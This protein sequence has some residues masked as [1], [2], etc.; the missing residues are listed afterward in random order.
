MAFDIAKALG[1][2]SAKPQPGRKTLQHIPL[3]MIDPNPRNLYSM[4]GITELADNIET[5]GLL[6]P[7]IVK[8]TDGGRYMV[9][10]GHRRRAALRM[11]AERADNY[12]QSMSEEVPCLVE[13]PD[14]P[15]PGIEDP[16]T[17]E[18]A[19]ALAEEL[20]LIYANADTRVLSSADT[21]MQ[22]R[23]IRELLTALRDLGYAMPGKMRDHV[24]A[25]AK[26]SASRIARLDVIE[27]GLMEPNLR[28]AWADGRLGETNAYEIARY[29]P[30]V[31]QR[32]CAKYGVDGLRSKKVE[33]V[34]L[35]LE[36][37]KTAE[38][39]DQKAAAA[40]NENVENLRKASPPESFSAEQYL[41]ERAKEDEAFAE[42]LDGLAEGFFREL[43]DVGSR[44]E[45]IETLKTKFGRSHVG[46][47]R[48]SG[49]WFSSAPK[50]LE[51]RNR[52]A[53]IS[54][55]I[56]RTWTEVYD[57]LCLDALYRVAQL[58]EPD[59]DPVSDED[60][61]DEA[62]EDLR[63]SAPAWLIGDP[64]H[65]GRYLC[66][67][68]IGPDETPHEQKMEWRSGE[69]RVFGNAAE[70]YQIAV[71]SWWPLPSA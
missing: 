39:Y 29:E 27:K 54:T 5:V 31:Q 26:V 49:L 47:T 21:A 18:K 11:V 17:A 41:A 24:A 8:Q 2:I 22:V 60:T 38:E 28:K 16:E 34:R 25:A 7:L 50:G 46:G 3:H 51:L 64:E 14:A 68:L 44:Q 70:K 20:K 69:W 37:A 65:D 12:P 40:W 30:R 10:S 63:I 9:I 1:D 33:E 53:E 58:P 32:A 71:Q 15:L 59:E 55:T 19:R 45:G 36:S 62:A 48:L 42:M 61:E 57:M 35:I 6:E 4:D 56:S 13:D 52:N 43:A 67:V 23:R 66:R